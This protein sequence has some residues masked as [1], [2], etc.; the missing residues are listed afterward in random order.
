MLK[1][2]GLIE[3]DH[4]SSSYT[5][6]FDSADSYTCGHATLIP[7]I[8]Y[9]TLLCG[10]QG[11]F[12]RKFGWWQH[13]YICMYANAYKGGKLLS[14]GKLATYRINNNACI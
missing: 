13:V 14:V 1:G 4:D 11:E 5:M 12:S 6:D 2:L 7:N 8:V 3:S 9:H 10:Y